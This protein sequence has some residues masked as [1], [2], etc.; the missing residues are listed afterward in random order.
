[1]PRISPQRPRRLFR[2]SEFG[3]LM[4]MI[5]ML[6]V[7]G[8]MIKSAS[9][10][11]TW[12]WLVNKPGQGERVLA[13]D[14]DGDQPPAEKAPG[15]AVSSSAAPASTATASTAKSSTG[16]ASTGIAS[17]AKTSTAKS[18]TPAASTPAPATPAASAPAASTPAPATSTAATHASIDKPAAADSAAADA[19]ADRPALDR[20]AMGERLA[21][22]AAAI[23]IVAPG[24]VE[25]TNSG[26]KLSGPQVHAIPKATGPTDQ[27]ED[28]IAGAIEDFD[29]IFDYQTSIRQ[30]ELDAYRRIV[31]WVI[32]QP[33][34][35][36]WR[37]PRIAILRMAN[38]SRIRTSSAS[39]ASC[40][41]W[42]SM[43]GE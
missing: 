43:C 2:G 36:C 15:K 33:Y 40:T 24:A 5:F 19:A 4:T 32:D 31:R 39:R 12:S 35:L 3:R 42:W 26:G 1:M 6:F 41:R 25:L 17:T 9:N 30:E 8:M 22:S 20:P 13:E 16:I 38:S 27:D 37:G 21:S 29:Y 10:P 11:G 18:S 28:E 23:P 7:L 14:R 34:A